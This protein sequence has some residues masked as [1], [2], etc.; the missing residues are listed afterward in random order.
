MHPVMTQ[1]RAEDRIRQFRQ[2]AELDR[3]VKASATKQRQDE[4]RSHKQPGVWVRR[5][6][7]AF[8]ASVVIALVASPAALAMPVRSGGGAGGGEIT[9]CVPKQATASGLCR[10]AGT[11]AI[12][13]VGEA[14]VAQPAPVPAEADG[15]G[16][17]GVLLWASAG[18]VTLAAG[19]GLVLGRHARV[20]T[21]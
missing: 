7:A 13:R 16:A 1:G 9:A 12:V 18:L 15:S 2:E 3:L 4:H 8:A 5:V 21:A 10:H 6:V 19:A 14:D 20:A 17:R 11:G